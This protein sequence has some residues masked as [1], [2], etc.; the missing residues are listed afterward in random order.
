MPSAGDA[1]AT[2]RFVRQHIVAHVAEVKRLLAHALAA[3]HQAQLAIVSGGAL[4][5]RVE[6]SGKRVRREESLV[7][8]ENEDA[9]SH[10][11]TVA[12]PGRFALARAAR[13]TALGCV[14]VGPAGQE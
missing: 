14:K 13:L 4:E 3:R 12:E 9:Q 5:E 8:S 7:A 2:W 11:G 6:A 1:A 10:A